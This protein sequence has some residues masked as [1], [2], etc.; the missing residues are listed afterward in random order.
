MRKVIGI[1]FLG[2]LLSGCSVFRKAGGSGIQGISINESAEPLDV[3]VSQNI[4]SKGFYIQKAE[5][6]YINGKNKE[7]FLASIKFEFPDKYLISVKSR[8]GIEGARIFI[9]KDSVY[10]NDR[11][12]KKMY[13]GSAFGLRRRFG[14]NQVFLPLIFGD[15]LLERDRRSYKVSC[16]E[17]KMI[18]DAYVR[19]AR[20]NY[21]IDC[22]KAKLFATEIIGSTA[23][24]G[25]KFKFGRYIK[26]DNIIIPGEIELDNMMPGMGIK[27]KILKLEY[28]YSEKLKFIPGKGYE[29]IELL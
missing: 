27:I 4:C 28:P 24:D 14:L 12:N 9:T 16:S 2:V 19:G 26:A 11:I 13:F 22:R 15:L 17:D 8:T 10:V 1:I 23:A 3:V 20:V 7:K 29:L 18:F 6:E 25:I 21:K 5:L